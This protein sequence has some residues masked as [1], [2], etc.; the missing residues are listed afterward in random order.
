MSL[1]GKIND[2]D[3]SLAGKSQGGKFGLNTGFFSVIELVTN[4][5][6]D[7]SP[8]IAVDV[9]VIIGEREYRRRLYDITGDL[10]GKGNV[11][12]SKT[13]EGYNEV[14]EDAMKQLMGVIVH[15]VKAVG[16]TQQA[17]DTILANGANNYEDWSKKVLSL[18][19]ADYQKR[20]ID[21][22]LEYQWNIADDQDKTYPELPKNMKGGRFLSPALKP[23][24]KWKEVI[25]ADGLYYVD[26][27]NIKHLF[28]RPSNFMD[29]N[30]GKQQTKVTSFGGNPNVPTESAAW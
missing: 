20:P 9:N 17:I 27:N 16:V 21:F 19:P 15:A 7:K 10:Y 5:G 3:E 30:K 26:D 25:D 24:G 8:G 14:Y 23:V 11:K 13:D 12:L 28:V 22:F 4:A 1:F 29:S 6:K 18:L 2:E